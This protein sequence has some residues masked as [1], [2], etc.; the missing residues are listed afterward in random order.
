MGC[1]SLDIVVRVRGI[2]VNL[3]KGQQ[4]HGFRVPQVRKRCL[5]RHMYANQ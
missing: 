3:E 4:T 2:D 5:F 1:A